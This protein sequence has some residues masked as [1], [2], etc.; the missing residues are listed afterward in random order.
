[1]ACLILR[2]SIL[3]KLGTLGLCLLLLGFV[4]VPVALAQHAG[5]HF[6]GGIGGRV[7][8]PPVSRPPLVRAPMVRPPLYI[9]PRYGAFGTG[10]LLFRT[11]PIHPLPPLFPVIGPP[12][13]FFGWPFWAFGPW[14]GF[15]GFGLGWGFNYC[16]WVNCSLFWNWQFAPQVQPFYE[17]TPAPPVVPVY[18][19][20]IFAYGERQSPQI[21]LKDGTV[22]N[23]LDYWRVD[24]QLHFTIHEP[25]NPN[26]AEHV[27]DLDQLDLQKTID[28]NTA[29]GFR[30]VMRDRPM[31]QY[32]HE[33]PNQI[34]PEW[35][36]PNNP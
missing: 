9:A 32:E 25:G 10:R 29:M 21:F 16:Y 8:V 34:P 12:F 36:R 33:R 22:Y 14:W 15:P 19:Y 11:Q 35:P 27:I 18:S 6:A 30:F 5:G 4:Q 31:E 17:Y 23:V 20:P 7:F 28:V 24:D 13:F 2:G 26:P 1:M 3:K